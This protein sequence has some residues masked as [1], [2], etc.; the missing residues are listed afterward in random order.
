MG[1]IMSWNAIGD[2][3]LVRKHPVEETTVGGVILVQELASQVDATAKATV[4]S[5]GSGKKPDGKVEPIAI[6]VGDTVLYHRHYGTD[7]SGTIP[8]E[9]DKDLM[10][11]S[12]EDIL[13]VV[14][15]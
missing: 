10:V 7:L 6:E 13:A 12:S 4:V 1:L 5:V 8:T 2:K 15:G 9:D 11:L 3:V 14:P